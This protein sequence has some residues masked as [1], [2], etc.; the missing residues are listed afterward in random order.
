MGSLSSSHTLLVPGPVLG[1]Y[2]AGWTPDTHLFSDL[3]GSLRGTEEAGQ[4]GFPELGDLPLLF[5]AS[6]Q[7]LWVT[8]PSC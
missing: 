8:S 3:L 5:P 1:E 4:A 7:Q 2:R 6:T